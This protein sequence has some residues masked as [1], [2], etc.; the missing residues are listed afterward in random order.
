MAGDDGDDLDRRI[1]KTGHRREQAID[2]EL[3]LGR[4]AER[5]EAL[6]TAVSRKPARCRP[7]GRCLERSSRADE[8]DRWCGR[9]S[10]TTCASVAAWGPAGKSARR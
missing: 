5:P 7:G 1:S 9:M 2:S 4:C 6:D 3:I 8:A 10:V